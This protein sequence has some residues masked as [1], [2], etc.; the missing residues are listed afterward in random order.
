MAVSIRKM[1]MKRL[2]SFVGNI[3]SNVT[4][5]GKVFVISFHHIMFVWYGCVFVQ[6]SRIP[7]LANEGKAISTN[8]QT[9]PI[10]VEVCQWRKGSDRLFQEILWNRGADS[11]YAYES[12]WILSADLVLWAF[13]PQ[14][15]TC[16]SN[17]PKP[18][19]KK[20]YPPGKIYPT[21]M[22]FCA[23]RSMKPRS[24]LRWRSKFL[25]L[26][27]PNLTNVGVDLQS[28]HSSL[29]EHNFWPACT[30]GLEEIF[31]R[32]YFSF[33]VDVPIS[34]TPRLRCFKN[35]NANNMMMY[36]AIPLGRPTIW[37]RMRDQSTR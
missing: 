23:L 15:K 16:Q 24:T 26:R 31:M 11:P 8:L 14:G 32:P 21:L 27:L 13:I 20:H 36:L 34:G 25:S 5:L 2:H 35:F 22:M 19:L 7:T 12:I 3:D 10:E 9:R 4:I 30:L 6:I 18:H 1:Q 29:N 17:T 28:S 33:F 37:K